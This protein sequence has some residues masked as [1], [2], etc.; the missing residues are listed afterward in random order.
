MRSYVCIIVLSLVRNL[1]IDEL[2]SATVPA[3]TQ[4]TGDLVLADCMKYLH[5]GF[6]VESGLH[7]V[8][9]AGTVCR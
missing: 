5:V 1:S 8:D 3:L 9:C 7:Q 6:Y 2:F 4:K